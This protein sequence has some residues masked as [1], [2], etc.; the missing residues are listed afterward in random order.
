MVSVPPDGHVVRGPVRGR[1]GGRAGEAGAVEERPLGGGERDVGVV[2][3]D[4][5]EAGFVC[6]GADEVGLLLVSVYYLCKEKGRKGR[7][8][9]KTYDFDELALLGPRFI[10]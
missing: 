1:A 2:G 4:G 8:Y 6:G 9:R 7:R 3:G 10:V 5:V